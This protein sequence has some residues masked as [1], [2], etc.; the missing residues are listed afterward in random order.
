MHMADA[1]V[2]PAVGGALWAGTAGLLAH[3]AREVR[4]RFDDRAV[5]LMGVL[6]AFVFAAQMV[7]FSIP[8]TGSSGHIGGGLLLAILLGPHAALIAMASVLAVQALIFADGG[9]L[10]LGCN[11]FNMGCI[12]A[13]VA[14][15]LVYRP[16]A[17]SRPDGARRTAAAV[18]AAVAALEL[19]ALGVVLE[20]TLSGISELP[21]RAF[22][23]LMLPVHFAIGLAEGLATAAVA[24]FVARARPEAI[25]SER[26]EGRARGLRP[27]TIGLLIGALAI[28]GA[29]SSLASGDPDG[30]EWAVAKLTGGK[31]PAGDA[32]SVREFL[33]DVQRRTAVLPEYSF[34]SDEPSAERPPA[35]AIDPGTSASGILG[36]LAVLAVVAAA[37][38]LLAARGRR[39]GRSPGAAPP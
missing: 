31:E 4:R 28:G 26:A 18:I 27:A 7:N 30:L 13:F 37:G 10:A 8:G 12:P 29:L 5:P 32:G 19:G 25:F 15:P 20:T 11:I 23:L 9:L 33:A 17:G 38:W 6:G 36:A 16:L 21:F 3:S 14:Y 2:S 22:L 24:G 1:L 34:R 35:S 39:S